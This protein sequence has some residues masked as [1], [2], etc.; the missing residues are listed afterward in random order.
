[1]N[2]PTITTEEFEAAL[3]EIKTTVAEHDQK[4]HNRKTCITCQFIDN[5]EKV[6]S[7]QRI[8]NFCRTTLMTINPLEQIVAAVDGEEHL[9]HVKIILLVILLGVNI[10]RN[11][12]LAEKMIGGLDGVR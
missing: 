9:H 10:G 3:S 4:R 12:V 11:Q 1:M 8:V 5:L 6:D 2:I 7:D